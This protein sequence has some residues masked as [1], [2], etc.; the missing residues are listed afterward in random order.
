MGTETTEPPTIVVVD[1]EPQVR[2]LIVASLA[3]LG[4][5]LLETANG[6]TAWGLV[7][8]H[9]PAVLVSNRRMPGRS[10][11]DLARAIKADPA[12]AD[13]HVIIVSGVE[14]DADIEEIQ[15]SGADRFI[16]KPFAPRV[17]AQAVIEGVL[18]R[19]NAGSP[20]GDDT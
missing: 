20:A 5:R 10:G 3:P 16:P 15:Q 7:R 14:D 13:T 17:L 11:P 1:D 12:T 6:E 4:Y 8:A 18:H 19:S 2:A 9:R